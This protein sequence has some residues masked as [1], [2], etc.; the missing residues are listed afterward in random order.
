M[1]G[2][3]AEEF[4]PSTSQ[5][6]SACDFSEFSLRWPSAHRRHGDPFPMPRLG[7]PTAVSALTRR[8]D[9]AIASLNRLAATVFDEAKTEDLKLTSVQTWMLNDLRRRVQSY[10]ECPSDLSEHQ[11]LADLM[12]NANLY[13]QEALNI[14]DYD[15]GEIKILQRRLAPFEAKELAP[16]EARAYLENFSSLVERPGQE[17]DSLRVSGD[18]VKPHWDERLRNSLRSCDMSCTKNFISVA[19]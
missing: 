18:L 16:P 12:S 9:S 7:R 4:P 1:G 13:D 6:A 8:T 10:G 17:M 5:A 3:A 14:A 11:A 2:G 15:I 19:C